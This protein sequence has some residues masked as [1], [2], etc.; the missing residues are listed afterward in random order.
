LDLFEEKRR[1]RAREQIQNRVERDESRTQYNKA[2]LD[3]SEVPKET[4][5]ERKQENAVLGKRISGIDDLH[6]LEAP[7]RARNAL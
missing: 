6:E 5:P 2:E 3:A 1:S 4:L 7:E